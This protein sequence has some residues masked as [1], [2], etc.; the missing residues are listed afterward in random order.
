MAETT[1]KKPKV[2]FGPRLIDHPLLQKYFPLVHEDLAA[3]YAR[4][5]HKWL[6]IAPIIGLS[7]GLVITGIA[8][9][10]QNMAGRVC[11]LPPP[12][13]DDHT[14]ADAGIRSDRFDHAI[15]DARSGRTFH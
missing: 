7:T 12:S 9:I 14:D 2:K 13:L 5:L 10:I 4:D 1:S 6:L 8:I 11:L 15:P 3:V